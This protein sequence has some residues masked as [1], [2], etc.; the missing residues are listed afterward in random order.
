MVVKPIAISGK[1]ENKVL[2]DEAEAEVPRAA[3]TIKEFC[4][5]HRISPAMYFKLRDAGLGPRE[6][7]TG[8]RVTISF[9][10][11]A[12]WRRAREHAPQATENAAA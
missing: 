11:A 2:S 10:A 3:F 6:M 12:D 9:E 5:A 8:R 4:E 7:R 1:A